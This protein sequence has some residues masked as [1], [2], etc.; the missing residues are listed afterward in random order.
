[1]HKICPKCHAEF[2]AHVEKCNVCDVPLVFP[3]H[4]ENNEETIERVIVTEF[5]GTTG[6]N[7]EMVDFETSPI[8]IIKELCVVLEHAN[9]A[10]KVAVVNN[11]ANLIRQQGGYPDTKYTLFVDKAACDEA[12]RVVAE[13]WAVYYPELGE[14]DEKV[15]LGLCPACGAHAGGLTECPDCGLNLAP[16]GEPGGGCNSCP[17]C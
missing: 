7:V 6:E 17:T 9:I 14:A 13:H 3:G 5:R 8:E 10:Y 12:K 11:D 16:G 15:K 4:E 2:Y 1:M